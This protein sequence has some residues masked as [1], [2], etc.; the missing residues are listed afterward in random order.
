MNSGGKQGGTSW[1]GSE[2]DLGGNDVPYI[3]GK[4]E[5]ASHTAMIKEKKRRFPPSYKKE[6]TVIKA[7]VGA[8]IRPLQ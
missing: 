7:Q 6:R 5:T 8:K 4:K 1:C 3:L 2:S